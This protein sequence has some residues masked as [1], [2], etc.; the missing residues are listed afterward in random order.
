MEMDSAPMAFKG[1][2][3]DLDHARWFAAGFRSI[4]YEISTVSSVASSAS[5]CGSTEIRSVPGKILIKLDRVNVAIEGR[6]ILKNICWSL[7]EGENW[8]IEGTNGSGKTTLLRLIR[9]VVWPTGSLPGARLYR[10]GRDV[11]ESPVGLERKI[12]YIGP[13]LQARYRKRQWGLKAEEIVLSGFWDGEFLH[14]RPRASEVRKMDEVF[15]R[16][17]LE[18]LRKRRYVR[19][20]EGELRKVLILRALIAEPTILLFDE[21]LGGL[22]AQSRR[23]MISF[24]EV[25]T[26]CN[27]QIVM[28]SHRENEI[29]ATITHVARLKTGKMISRARRALVPIK[30]HDCGTDSIAE[31]RRTELMLRR[32]IRPQFGIELSRVN[33][34]LAN[35]QV[36]RDFDWVVEP[37]ESW[38]LQGANGSG[39]TVLLKLIYG[40]YHAALGGRVVRRYLDRTLS[41]VEARK[42]IGWVS[43]DLQALLLGSRDVRGIVASGFVAGVEYSDRLSREQW[44][45]V[46]EVLERYDIDD[47]AERP[48][49]SLSYGQAR[50][51]LVARAVVIDP[52]LLL[53][54]EPFEGLDNAA[55]EQMKREITDLSAEGIQL[56]MSTHHEEDFP[57]SITHLLELEGGRARGK[58]SLM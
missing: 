39:K 20:S 53:L 34:Y 16:F 28:T 55:R 21:V 48:F 52:A 57:R 47:L 4:H 7:R 11:S 25:M 17:G 8:L 9:G 49:N 31:L 37:E 46:D 58:T 24:L 50:M 26:R 19:L 35:R 41:V 51:V 38:A 54:D 44:R 30:R 22:D 45:S 3:I 27:R 14:E 56:I 1:R 29:P 12:A 36:L 18:D 43:A 32:V 5:G 42:R 40:A 6:S 10:I 2:Q 33:L 23:E 13:E 15:A